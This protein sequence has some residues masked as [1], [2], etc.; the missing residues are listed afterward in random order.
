MAGVMVDPAGLWDL[1]NPGGSAMVV[2]ALLSVDKNYAEH[3]VQQRSKQ[4]QRPL[5]CAASIDTQRP[6]EL[7][8]TTESP[9]Q[10]GC[11]LAS[12]LCSCKSCFFTCS[13]EVVWMP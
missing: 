3:R 8:G 6:A 12:C 4:T 9:S 13:A 1:S 10:S 5:S 11:L 2:R 7:F